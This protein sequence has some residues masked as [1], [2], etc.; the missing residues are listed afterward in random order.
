[1]VYTG[2]HDND[3]TQGWYWKLPVPQR[4][5]LRKRLGVNDQGI[6]WA[7]I[8]EAFASKAETAIIPVQDLLELGSEG[9]MNFPGIAEGN[10][11]WRLKDGVLTPELAQRLKKLT[12]TYGRLGCHESLQDPRGQEGNPTQQIAKGELKMGMKNDK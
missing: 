7:M 12:T 8:R 9:R 5:T 11:G 10:W 1:V 3:T 4:E 6:V 2:T